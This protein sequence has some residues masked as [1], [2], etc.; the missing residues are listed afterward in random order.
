MENNYSF[1]VENDFGISYIDTLLIALFY[2]PSTYLENMLY[3]EPKNIIG[4]YLQEIIKNNFVDKVR[5]KISVLSDTILEILL[6]SINLNW[7]NYGTMFNQQPI[8]DFYVFLVNTFN[9]PQ[10]DLANNKF[11]VIKFNIPYSDEISIKDLCS[12]LD[13]ISNTPTFIGFYFDRLIEDNKIDTKIDIQKK[14]KLDHKQGHPNNYSVWKIHSIICHTGNTYSDGHYYSLIF[15]DNKW[16]LY[17]N[18]VTP[19]IKECNIK[20]DIVSTEIKQN[21]IMAFY[22]YVDK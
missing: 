11:P 6:C 4:V 18:K 13:P 9:C 5:K 16:L 2:K 3:T 12:T 10:P 14:I 15:Y 8:N 19:C 1:I 22:C 21:I 20:D 17:N 7:V